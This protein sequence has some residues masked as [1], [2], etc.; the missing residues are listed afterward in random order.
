MLTLGLPRS[1]S[2]THAITQGAL[3]PVQS[4]I[5]SATS[6]GGHVPDARRVVIQPAETPHVGG[7]LV[8]WRVGGRSQTAGRSHLSC[9]VTVGP[10]AH[11]S[12]QQAIA[13]GAETLPGL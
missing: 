1:S 5:S 4:A 2:V 11:V 7:G 9:H 12:N 13:A 6:A 3:I 8:R 10:R